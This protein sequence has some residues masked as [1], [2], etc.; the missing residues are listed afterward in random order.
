MFTG[1]Q[2]GPCF[3]SRDGTHDFLTLGSSPNSK[4]LDDYYMRKYSPEVWAMKRH[5]E[6]WF[7]H[8][9]RRIAGGILY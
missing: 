5:N 3:K 2:N 4:G 9:L 7:K 1:N 6:S 8:L